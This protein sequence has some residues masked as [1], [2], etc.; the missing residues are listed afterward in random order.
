MIETYAKS[1]GLGVIIGMRALM[2]PALLSRKLARTIPVSEPQRPVHYFIQPPVPTTLAVLAATE[3]IT[4]KLPGI[5]NRTVPF[6]FG[7]RLLSGG[8]CG[9]VLS[10]VEGE[11]VLAGSIAGGVG[12]A[13]GTIATF[14]LRQWLTHTAG[15]PDSVVALAEDMLCVGAGWAIV[16]SI[17]PAQQRAYREGD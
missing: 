10:E 17:E 1:F 7:G 12:A 15:L 5:P 9:A 11:S 6:Q 3:I 13:V 2:G 16:N 8:S 14:H 4:D